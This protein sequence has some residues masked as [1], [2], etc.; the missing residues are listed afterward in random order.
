[1]G[2]SSKSSNKPLMVFK[3]TDPEYFVEDY[4]NAVTANLSLNV[5]PEPVNTP[6]HQ[7]WI[8]KRTALIQ[9]TLDGAAQKSFSVLPIEIKSDWKIFT[10]EFSR[11][12]DYERNKQHERVLCYEIRELPN[13]TIKKLAVSIKS[14]SSN[15]SSIRE[16]DFIFRKLVDKL[17]QAE[18]NMKLEETENLKL[19]YVNNIQATTSQINIIHDSDT[20]LSEKITEILNTYE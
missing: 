7:N 19:H 15:P 12:F 9:T 8:H 11:R 13:E 3:G 5:G 18:I 1:M 14:S 16:P 2:G 6:L 17:E 4:L 10:Q 20:D